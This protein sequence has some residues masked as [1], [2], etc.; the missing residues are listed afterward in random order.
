MLL[1]ATPSFPSFTLEGL[2]ELTRCPS[3]AL[4]SPGALLLELQRYKDTVSCAVLGAEVSGHRQQQ[5]GA[6]LDCVF[7]ESAIVFIL[8]KITKPHGPPILLPWSA[9]GEIDV[10]TKKLTT[11]VFMQQQFFRPSSFDWIRVQAP[12][13]IFRLGV[14]KY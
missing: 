5:P 6:N 3:R 14:K 2:F 8:S 4:D 7:V 10:L 13:S 9:F 12:N 1:P 11:L